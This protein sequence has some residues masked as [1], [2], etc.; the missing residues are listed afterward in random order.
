MHIF[1]RFLRFVRPFRWRLAWALLLVFVTHGLTLPIPKI[2]AK[3][4]DRIPPWQGLEPVARAAKRGELVELL[5]IIC[6]II[7]GLHLLTALI[8][9]SR[10]M[11]I[12]FVGQRVLFDV[13]TAVYRHLQR[14]SLRYYETRSTG[15]IMARVLYDVDAIQSMLSGGLVDMLS[16]TIMVIVLVPLLFFMHVKLAFIAIA[17]VPLY[18]MNFLLLRK[19]IHAA[20][21]EVRNQYS[22]VYATLHES[23]AGVKVVKSFVRERYEARRFVRELREQ[24]RLGLRSARWNQLMGIGAGLITNM[25]NVIILYIGGMMVLTNPKAL[26]FGDLVAF[27][28]YLGMLFGPVIALV[29]INQTIQNV[30]AAIERIMDTLDSVPEIKDK[31][32]ARS[33][34]EIRGK[35][36]FREVDFAYEPGQLVLEDI[37]F[38]AEPGQM[39]ALVGPSGGGKSTLVNLIPRF[40]D[41]LNGAVL[42]DDID[43][44]DFRTSTLRRNIGIVL[45]ET[46]LFSGTLRENI[47]YGKPDATDEEVIQAAMA[48]NAHD[49]IM[50]FP[51]GYE[52]E[53]GERGVRLSGGQ[54][55]RIS[56][57]RAILRNPRILILDE[58]TSALDSESEFLIQ[59]ALAELMKHRTS[60]VI[61][62]RLSTVM[63][64]DLILVLD[65][66]RIVE[67]GVHAEL[68]TQPNGLY[69]HL[70]EIQFKRAE[71]KLRE[72]EA[73]RASKPLG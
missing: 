29:T 13:R 53:V 62:H 18:V 45:Q 3:L 6:G 65:E 47:K 9:Y 56:I 1:L 38:V 17:F 61:A 7:V 16:N 46:F 58:A 10:G 27:Q 28:T 44:R 21:A 30:L 23:I 43:L 12:A 26:T 68:A 41:P 50:E 63:N 37:S 49:F 2:T 11:A 32:T 34:A 66:G 24:V 19:R 64:A 52:T 36:E 59:R 48:A 72:Y 14:L 25:A 67:R 4:I 35:V 22:E 71:E 15:R 39:I 31:P 73:Q 33:P 51:D 55:Q 8:S 20:A 70:C 69:A 5:V 42:V 60:F 57:A 40:Y 54:R